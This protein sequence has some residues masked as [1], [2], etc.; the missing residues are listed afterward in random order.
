MAEILRPFADSN[1]PGQPDGRL[2]AFRMEIE[3]LES[4]RAETLR[5]YEDTLRTL[6]RQKQ[7]TA[8]LL[9]RLERTELQFTQEQGR[10]KK[11][12]EMIASY[13]K[14]WSQMVDNDRKLRAAFTDLQKRTKALDDER[15]RLRDEKSVNET[16][17]TRIKGELANASQNHG[18]LDRRYRQLQEDLLNLERLHQEHQHNTTLIEEELEHTKTALTVSEQNHA[19]FKEEASDTRFRAEQLKRELDVAKLCT[20]ELERLHQEALAREQKCL[21]EIT[22]CKNTIANLTN[23]LSAE[24]S[25]HKD[26]RERLESTERAYEQLMKDRTDLVRR[27]DEAYAE[28]ARI[29]KILDDTRNQAPL[30]EA[31]LIH[32]RDSAIEKTKS[33]ELELN[34]QNGRYANATAE[35]IQV[36]E[37][38]NR[39]SSS[40]LLE[41]AAHKA[42]EEALNKT[43]SLYQQL[44]G[45]RTALVKRGDEAYREVAHFQIQLEN[46]RA[47]HQEALLTARNL[48]AELSVIR[49]QLRQSEQDRVTSTCQQDALQSELERQQEELDSIQLSL[50]SRDQQE[51]QLRD[52]LLQSQTL[53]E[54]LSEDRCNLTQENETI[55]GEL[56]DSQAA[57]ETAREELRAQKH[58]VNGIKAALSQSLAVSQNIEAERGRLQNELDEVR[59]GAEKSRHDFSLLNQKLKRRST[60]ERDPFLSDHNIQP[61]C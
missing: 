9:K 8:H 30:T 43:E 49:D 33:L 35:N 53:L 55:R 37:E 40:L 51:Q 59:R 26:N 20:H 56:R 58:E 7:V 27:G 45:D 29:S 15:I 46:L 54:Q 18:N 25:A 42:T 5:K 44:M 61:S 23:A 57:L 38:L 10:M 17:L 36:S 60:D 41:Q 32:E 31:K 6:G 34:A 11:A 16:E 13:S 4:H 21:T 3:K 48:E 50:E 52:E 2:L 12:Q 28:L 1:K 47:E 24:R 39:R 19:R 22:D 14:Q